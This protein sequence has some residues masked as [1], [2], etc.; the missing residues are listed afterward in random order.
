MH[1]DI[2]STNTMKDK[3]GKIWIVDFGTA[4]YSPR[5]QEMARLNVGLLFNPDNEDENTRNRIL[6]LE[7]Y[8][9]IIQLTERELEM[10]PTYTR[11]TFAMDL[12]GSICATQH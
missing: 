1:G 5:I 3:K 11:L 4:N 2:V 10:L 12:M 8:Q 7:E 9:K 6:A